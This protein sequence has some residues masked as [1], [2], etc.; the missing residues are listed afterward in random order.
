MALFLRQAP[1]DARHDPVLRGALEVYRLERGE[2]PDALGRLVDAG[3][4][5]GRDLS[6]PW[7]EPYFYRRSEGRFVL[8]PPVE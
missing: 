3:L 8:L 7:S 4:A 5:S 6:Y 2:Y 1:H